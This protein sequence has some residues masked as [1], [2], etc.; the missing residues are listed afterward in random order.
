MVIN[1]VYRQQSLLYRAKTHS[2][3][4]KIVSIAQPHIRPIAR[5]KARAAFEFGAK[6]SASITEHG[7]LYIDRMQWEPYNEGEDL[8]MQAEKYKQR[9]G[10]YPASIH[11]DKIY[12]TRDN[13]LF[14]SEH[15][16]RLSGP[17]L[18]RPPLKTPENARA[19]RAIRRIERSDEA[20]RQA[21]EGGFGRLKRKMTLANV[22]E[23]LKATSEVTIMV[24]F[25]LANCE[26]ILRDLFVSFLELLELTLEFLK[27]RANAAPMGILLCQLGWKS[28]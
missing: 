26:K 11:A 8:P 21:I 14:C 23:K 6:I 10:R 20:I 25:F 22:Y 16:I 19:L 27:D 4:G 5:G 18:G 7:M 9:F 2:I 28:C 15:G 24:C 1:E 17:H 13:R 12:R 3:P